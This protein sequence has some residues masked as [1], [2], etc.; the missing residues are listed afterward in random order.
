[1]EREFLPRLVL[2][3]L[4]EAEVPARGREEMPSLRALIRSVA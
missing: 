2:S 1:M 4:L 3:L